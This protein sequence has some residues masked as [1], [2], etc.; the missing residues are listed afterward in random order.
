MYSPELY[1][2]GPD[3][4]APERAVELTWEEIGANHAIQAGLVVEVDMVNIAFRAISGYNVPKEPFNGAERPVLDRLINDCFSKYPKAHVHASSHLAIGQVISHLSRKV[5]GVTRTIFVPTTAYGKPYVFLGFPL[6]TAPEK[7]ITSKLLNRIDQL[8]CFLNALSASSENVERLRV[9]ELFVKEV[10]HDVA[11][12]VQAIIAKVR[13][14]RDGR[15]P[16]QDSLKRKAGEIEREINSA[17][18]IA[19][20]LGL[21]IDSDYQMRSYADFDITQIATDAIEQ[22]LAEAEERNIKFNIETNFEGRRHLWGDERAIQQCL[23]Q[24]CLNAVKYSFGGTNIKVALLDRGDD[25]VIQIGNKGYE[26]PKGD[27]GIQ[28]WNFGVRGKKAKELHVNGSGIGLYTVRKIVLAHCG[29]TWAEG[30][31]DRTTFT[32]QIPKREKM[33]TALGWLI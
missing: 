8:L 9:T 13:T 21:A 30:N 22:L 24:L 33:R 32:V 1:P 3:N 6:G 31:G 25:I 14:I 4:T 17:Y 20:M 19:D 12:S 2:K 29:R 5:T 18:G 10:G 7:N 15:F 23:T 28:I 11:S 27:E 16:D 26:L